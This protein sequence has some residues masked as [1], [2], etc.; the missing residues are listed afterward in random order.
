M[1]TTTGPVNNELPSRSSNDKI[2]GDVSD[3]TKDLDKKPKLSQSHS[4]LS[5]DV[6]KSNFAKAI[7]ANNRGSY[8]MNN[9][10][11]AIRDQAEVKRESYTMGLSRAQKHN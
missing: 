9:F 2:Q 1:Q 4:S 5:T 6:I 7:L 10:Q 3:L 11:R 8:R